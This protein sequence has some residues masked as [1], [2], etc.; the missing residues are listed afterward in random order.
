MW[1]TNQR[2]EQEFIGG[3]NDWTGAASVAAACRDF[4]ADVEEEIVADEPLSCY[5]CRYRRWSAESFTCMKKS[6]V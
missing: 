1:F 5:N 3:K 2:G 6:A 4:H